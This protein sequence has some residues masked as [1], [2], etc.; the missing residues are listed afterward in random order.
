LFATATPHA[1]D[2]AENAQEQED[3]TAKQGLNVEVVKPFFI[4]GTEHGI[5]ETYLRFMSKFVRRGV[6]P[7]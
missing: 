3:V 5:G 2:A 6:I 7:S 4:T 1:A